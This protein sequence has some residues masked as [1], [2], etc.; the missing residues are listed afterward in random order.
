MLGM[1]CISPGR[2]HI[3]SRCLTAKQRLLEHDLICVTIPGVTRRH[4]KRAA[5]YLNGSRVLIPDDFCECSMLCE[6]GISFISPRELPYR[7]AVKI[8]RQAIADFKLDPRET[9][10]SVTA[11]R[12]GR[13]AE[14]ML[15]ELAQCARYLSLS[16]SDVEGVSRTLLQR[17]GVAPLPYP[18]AIEDYPVQ[19]KLHLSKE[20]FSL[21][22][23]KDG[24]AY[25]FNRVEIALPKRFSI[26]PQTHLYSAATALLQSGELLG[27]EIT[28]R[29][30]LYNE[31]KNI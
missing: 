3:W 16:C 5:R 9:V 22:I 7:L 17:C 20:D 6:C 29:S 2:A 15:C 23:K 18:P 4:L 1:L 31:P 28:V 12:I 30:V 24:A 14:E 11:G 27:K 8:Y 19:A 25:A 10:L 26:L 21:L 13:D